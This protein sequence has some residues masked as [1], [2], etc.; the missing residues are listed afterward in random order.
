M[1]KIISL[2]KYL[3][4][5]PLSFV[6]LFFIFK[7]VLS[8]SGNL[9]NL[10]NINYLFL[11]LGIIF[12]QL[13][14]FLRSVLW[15]EIIKEKGNT[16]PF[17]KS[18]YFW[19]IS[20]IK[21]YTP[22]NIWSFLSRTKL[23]TEENMTTQNM[24]Y[25]L[26]N[27]TV[28]I[29]LGCFLV[30]V[31]Y[32]SYLFNNILINYLLILLSFLS[33]ILYVYAHKINER[34]QFKGIFEKIKLLLPDNNYNHN[35]K[36]YFLA[37]VAFLSFGIATYFSSIAIFYLNPKDIL[38]IVSLSVFSLLI[39]YLSIVTPMGLGVREGV[40]TLGLSNFINLT[41]AGVISIFTRI[42]FILSEVIFLIIVFIINK[43]KINLLDKLVILLKKYKYELIVVCSS[44]T[45]FLYYTVSSFLRYDNFFTGRFDLGNMDQA[46]WNTI[47]GRIFEITNPNGTEIIS[48]LAFH[49]DFILVLLSPF[50]LIWSNPKMLLIIQTLVLSFG[51]VFIFLI[52]SNI[53]K[54]KKISLAFSLAYLINPS[55]GYANLYDFHPV[56]LATTF[57]LACFYFILKKDYKLFLLFAI[58][59]GLT[60]EH[61][62][63][64]IALLGLFVVFTFIKE[65]GF[66]IKTVSKE[67][68][69]CLLVFLFSISI[70]YYLIWHAIPAQT[71]GNH[72]ALSYYSDFGN[73]AS[74]VTKNILLNPLKILFLI[75]SPEKLNYLS[76]IL[77]PV[78]FLP[79]L[80]PLILLISI[81]DLLVNL[82]SNNSQLHQ[83][84]YQYTSTTT[85]FLF[86]AAI[87]SI[88]FFLNKFRNINKVL[89]ITY[90][91][92]FAFFAQ[93]SLGPLPGSKKPNIDMFTKQLGNKD[94]I[95][96]YISKIPSRYSISATNNLG[97][98][99]SR[100]QEIFTIPLG[101]EK[102]DIVMFLL[103]DKFAQPSLEQQK[104]MAKNMENDKNYIL[105][106]KNGDFV[107]FQRRSL[108]LMPKSAKDIT[109]LFP[110]S[111]EAL[112]HREY[113][114]QDLKIEK[115]VESNSSFT[116]YI[117]SYLSD[118][119]KVYS[120]MNIP[121]KTP[122]EKGFPVIIINHGYIQPTLYNTVSSYKTITDYFSTKGFIVLKPDY[123]GNGNSEIEDASLMRFAYPV[124]VLNLLSSVK[125][126][127][128]VDKENVFLWSHSMGGEVT[129]TV[130]EIASQ[131]N[132]L[133]SLVKGAVFWAPVTDPAKWFSRPNLQ[134]LPEARLTP[135]PYTKTFKTLGTPEE[136]PELWQTLSPLNYLE[137]INVPILLQ[138]GTSD[139][140]VPYSWSVELNKTMKK[141][142]KNVEFMSYP[143]DNHN[144]SNSWA[145][146][147]NSDLDFY[148]NL[149]NK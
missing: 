129:L 63:A 68:V 52:G 79:L 97:S 143:N 56:T 95:E 71:G 17:V 133:S 96:N 27:E 140:F 14:F 80:S 116:S 29:I 41:S 72:F 101:M 92:F 18:T 1:N 132:N 6:S 139:K 76:D 130:L 73:S 121:N 9:P 112:L 100:R 104:L 60:K 67:V 7:L 113:T 36:V 58:L 32:V 28:L 84:Y 11:F 30:S 45:Y 22:G 109:T 145:S 131:K 69:I 98:H 61:V 117:V 136:N 20:E 57:L 146:V 119:L 82:L 126:I 66:K 86:I 4:G 137:N 87:Y 10:Q 91:L 3:I 78:G 75:F 54:D 31:F 64:I 124:D 110:F 123:R 50:Y 120:L 85:P 103:N 77:S 138:H 107:V 19:E 40:M 81:P 42:I 25:S 21:R 115:Q 15:H 16:I 135:Y 33:I 49:A 94:V 37:F 102:A 8:N 26:F 142:N 149:I 127:K 43:V 108:Y 128:N 111:I 89:I 83:I 51:A 90:I 39:G 141:I 134:K 118:G 46:V 144:L 65:Q 47:H 147:T 99:L 59:A 24:V 55:V 122:P 34:I 74:E 12:F 2:L 105:V 48:R 53:L 13:Y 88:S 114:S 70:F 35:F 44:F 38:I 23:F 106:F 125:N 148:L 62:W 93:Y 5:W